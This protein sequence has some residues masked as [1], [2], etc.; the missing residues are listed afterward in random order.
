MRL[1]GSRL[2]GTLPTELGLVS[3]FANRFIFSDDDGEQTGVASSISGTLPTEL[4]RLGGLFELSL[5]QSRLSGTIPSQMGGL[6]TMGAL[7]LH[8]NRLSGSLP[9]E[10][11]S[12]GGFE[13]NPTLSTFRLDMNRLSGSIPDQLA[14]LRTTAYAQCALNRL[15][16]SSAHRVQGSAQLSCDGPDDVWASPNPTNTTNKFT[17]GRVGTNPDGET[18]DPS[19]PTQIG[20]LGRLPPIPCRY[21]CAAAVAGGYVRNLDPSPPLPSPPPY[22]PRPGLP[23]RHPPTLPAPPPP[24]ATPRAPPPPLS[25]P[26][27]VPPPG[28][29]PYP[30]P[31]PPPPPTA[32]L[33]ALISLF[34]AM[35]GPGWRRGGQCE[36]TCLHFGCKCTGSAP[37][38]GWRPNGSWSVAEACN[39]PQWTI[40]SGWQRRGAEQL[41]C[42]QDRVA[43]LALRGLR[44]SGTLPSRAIG[45][46][47]DLT[48]LDLSGNPMLSGT[49]PSELGLLTR[50]RALHVDSTAF[51]GTLPTGLSRTL[52]QLLLTST[53]VSGT[54]PTTLGDV[55][56]ALTGV[57][58]YHLCD[59]RLSGT[60]PETLTKLPLRHGQRQHLSATES[61]Y[62]LSIGGI[63]SRE[64]DSLQLGCGDVGYPLSYGTY[65]RLSG[66]IPEGFSK[67]PRGSN[68]NGPN[69][70]LSYS[71]L[72]GTIS[73]SAAGIGLVGNLALSG[74]LPRSYVQNAG[75]WLLDLS[76]L[77]LSGTLPDN[78]QGEWAR[79]N[80]SDTALSGTLPATLNCLGGKY[81]HGTG[82]CVG[83]DSYVDMRRSHLSGTIPP[84]LGK[85]RVSG[86]YLQQTSLSGTVP[87][88]ACGAGSQMFLD[89]NALSGTLPSWLTGRVPSSAQ[90]SGQ[91][92]NQACQYLE[93]LTLRSNRLSGTLPSFRRI[94]GVGEHFPSLLDVSQNLLSGTLPASL[95]SLAPAALAV[96]NNRMSGS[97]PQSLEAPIDCPSAAAGMGCLQECQLTGPP[98]G[99]AAGSRA[100]DRPIVQNNR[101]QCAN[102]VSTITSCATDKC[103]PFFSDARIPLCTFDPPSPPPAPP[104]PPP[105]PPSP[106]PPPP[107]PP[108]PAVPPVAPGA[109][110][111][112]AAVLHFW[113]AGSS[114]YAFDRDAFVRRLSSLLQ[115][116]AVNAVGISLTVTSSQ[117]DHRS[118]TRMG[119]ADGAHTARELSSELEVTATVEVKSTAAAETIVNAIPAIGRTALEAELG[120]AL[121]GIPTAVRTTLVLPA[122]PSPSPPLD[123]T[124]V[125][126]GVAFGCFAGGL[127]VAACAFGAALRT[128][129]QHPMVR[130]LERPTDTPHKSVRDVELESQLSKHAITPAGG[131]GFE[132]AEAL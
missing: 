36:Q 79:V 95:A 43:V 67:L 14:R 13:F 38:E 118:L 89:A 83:G 18:F 81:S 113:V 122:P 126:V 4:G 130:M 61:S 132:M 88:E 78:M 71:R 2:S 15:C 109:S 120:V 106:P 108:P 66:T 31:P 125:I 25:P 23:P 57:N 70:Y 72:S 10:L 85:L 49:L 19:Y 58:M 37:V 124:S 69:V 6:M 32:E 29:P 54:I 75:E 16:R 26:P 12:V 5:S 17:C 45:E 96:Q 56:P 34:T 131:R 104:L 21:T 53:L 30:P 98:V 127:L 80:L 48:Y 11:A 51:S 93:S 62:D 107:S 86:L 101:F 55:D 117:S 114:V 8:S 65:G 35:G 9:S 97:I 76:G 44:L 52:Q 102:G 50:L 77:R 121:D 63:G 73:E 94:A 59:T 41:Q 7:D 91:G 100:G 128:R 112:P 47:T 68:A 40:M 123:S 20:W 90:F 42:V 111:S 1:Q 87:F 28:P 105:M 74:T 92:D 82:P 24:P 39:V 46:L 60:I 27:P 3:I 64:M 22:I 110:A 119:H 103:Q 115:Q 84:Q 116:H 99:S 33:D 129:S